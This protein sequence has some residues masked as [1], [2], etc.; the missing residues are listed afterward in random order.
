MMY[1]TSSHPVWGRGGGEAE[2]GG[3]ITLRQMSLVVLNALPFKTAVFLAARLLYVPVASVQ[4]LQHRIVG[5]PITTSI[6]IS[7]R[8]T[9]QVFRNS[10]GGIPNFAGGTFD[11]PML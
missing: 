8:G 11:F 3:V 1:H 5:S 9:F 4:L 7:T 6:R 2:R 10:Q